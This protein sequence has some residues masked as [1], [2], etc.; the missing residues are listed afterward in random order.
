[1]EAKPGTACVVDKGSIATFGNETPFAAKQVA[2]L[3]SAEGKY[4]N[5][6]YVNIA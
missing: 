2:N 1:L 3:D 4:N 6:T 5:T